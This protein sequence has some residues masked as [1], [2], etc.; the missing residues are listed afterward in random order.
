MMGMWVRG[1]RGALVHGTRRMGLL[2][3]HV[4]GMGVKN[5]QG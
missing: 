2:G 5:S 4:H 1:C 3:G